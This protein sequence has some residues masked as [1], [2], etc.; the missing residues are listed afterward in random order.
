MKIDREAVERFVKKLKTTKT[1]LLHGHSHSIYLFAMY[2]K[3][4]EIQY[5]PNSI[6]STSMMLIEKERKFIEDV[7]KCKVSDLYGCEEV[8]L[9]ACE[10]EQHNGLHL[11]IDN[12]Y[13]EFLDDHKKSVQN[14]KQGKIIV[15]SLVN[16]AMPLVRYSIE[17]IGV[18]SSRKCLCG[19]S[20]PIMEKVIG[21]VADFIEREDGSLV[22]GV[23][24]VE[25]TLTAIKGI[26]QMQI[27]QEDKENITV[28]IVKGED[29]TNETAKKL[30]RE[31]K[32]SL[33]GNL[34]INL[35]YLGNIPR[36]ASGKYRFSI[37]RVKNKLTGYS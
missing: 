15:T 17:D 24:L 29:F 27:I 20:L 8:G 21:R 7:F 22:A 31:L 35:S 11:N 14:G 2:C 30:V 18:P 32:I 19:R 26:V 23:S 16:K 3:E 10:C 6:I 33:G 12:L 28:N 13:I 1:K 25:R 9:I 34:N 4:F 5:R 37:S 36:E